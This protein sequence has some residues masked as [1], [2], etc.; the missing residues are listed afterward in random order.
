MREISVKRYQAAILGGVLLM[1]GGS[2]AGAA[3]PTTVKVGVIAS[4]SGYVA[5]YGIDERDASLL[6][7]DEINKQNAIP[8][9][10]L[11]PIVIDDKGD[12]TATVEA[13]QQALGQGAT[14]IL[15]PTT[16]GGS[17]AAAG[18]VTSR[19]IPAVTY[20]ILPLQF[21]TSPPAY[22]FSLSIDARGEADGDLAV[23]LAQR[24]PIKN[25][26]IIYD[27][28]TYGQSISEGLKASLAAKGINLVANEAYKSTDTD[29]TPQ[30]SRIRNAKPDFIFDIGGG[31]APALIARQKSELG[32]PQLMLISVGSFGIGD[33]K[34]A[35]IA[36]VAASSSVRAAVFA[37]QVWDSLPSS[38]PRRGRISKFVQTFK[39]TY[40]RDP[41][42][43]APMAG[44]DAAWALAYAMK[45]AGSSDPD[46]VQAALDKTKFQG[47]LCSVEF[48]PASHSACHANAVVA[49]KMVNGKLEYGS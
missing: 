29:M 13:I 35:E 36:G 17:G 7:I 25:V 48:S 21:Q 6:A 38:D 47:T 10:K 41:L 30:L 23:A 9:V 15:G 16:S 39:N 14:A 26:A 32:M 33:K 34:L 22:A 8:G 19:K 46:K 40:K 3:G 2:S 18:V 20:G 45:Q 1:V 31:T 4:L 5:S 11:E 24:I 44:Y 28:N 43:Y 27:S 37:A 42:G 12:P 49:G